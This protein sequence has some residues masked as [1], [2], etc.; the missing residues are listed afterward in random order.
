M[1][2]DQAARIARRLARHARQPDR[3]LSRGLVQRLWSLL[4]LHPATRGIYAC[5]TDRTLAEHGPTL[6]P[7][8]LDQ[9]AEHLAAAPP[10]GNARKAHD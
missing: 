9:A 5:P 6:T 8:Q 2:R 7:D 10:G 1:N 3:L 4:E